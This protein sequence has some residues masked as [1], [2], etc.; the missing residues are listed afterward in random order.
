MRDVILY[1]RRRLGG[2]LLM[3]WMRRRRRHTR[4][5]GFIISTDEQA[6]PNAKPTVV[7]SMAIFGD[8]EL[9][10]MTH[11]NFWRNGYA[12]EA[13]TA[14]IDAAWKNLPDV[15]K[16]TAQVDTGNVA[17]VRTLEKCGFREVRREP[18]E[19]KTLGKRFL[20]VKEAVRPS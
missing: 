16:I 13:I 15:E 20:I 14:F 10:Y 12:S 11:P 1:R 8:F 17:S 3:K 9:G 18:Y 2:K 4:T 7:G 6:Q 5:L 19:S